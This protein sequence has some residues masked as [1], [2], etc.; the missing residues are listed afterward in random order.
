M[1]PKDS[2][3]KCLRSIHIYDAQQG[4]FVVFQD[5]LHA[6]KSSLK[7]LADGDHPTPGTIDG[8]PSG[9][10][11]T[12]FHCGKLPQRV[13]TSSE[14][15]TGSFTNLPKLGEGCT[16]FIDATFVPHCGDKTAERLATVVSGKYMF[17]LEA[18]RLVLSTSVNSDRQE[19]KVDA[20]FY[21]ASENG[22][23]FTEQST[24]WKIKCP[25]LNPDLVSDRINHMARLAA[26]PSLTMA[27]ETWVSRKCCFCHSEN[28]I[29]KPN[30]LHQ[31]LAI[32][33]N[34]ITGEL[35]LQYKGWVHC[36]SAKCKQRGLEMSKA[37]SEG[38]QV[39]FIGAKKGFVT[40]S[41]CGLEGAK[42]EMKK[43]ARCKAQAYCSADCQRLDWPQHKKTCVPVEVAPVDNDEA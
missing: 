7:K 17:E 24:T 11:F 9:R 6:P 16:N 28:P 8:R 12:C 3:V 2:N 29:T 20:L 19:M 39:P 4:I 43:C 41:N 23:A 15:R 5:I 21:S 33:Q 18:T 38:L 13:Q 22:G 14:Y 1:A 32:T 42:K 10:P 31:Y 27:K 25:R 37:D 40:C 34:Q 26:V 30:D 35:A 36:G